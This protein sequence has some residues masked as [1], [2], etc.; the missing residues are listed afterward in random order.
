MKLLS[1]FLFLYGIQYVGGQSP[2]QFC[3][4]YF[5]P[6]CMGVDDCPKGKYQNQ[7]DQSSCKNCNYGD[8]SDQTK[9]VGC[10]ECPAGQYTGSTTFSNWHT[11]CND[12]DVGY[13]SD[14]NGKNW[15]TL[16]NKCSSGKYY[17]Q[18]TPR[19]S[20]GTCK[21]CAAGKW[22]K[23]MG[24]FW[25]STIVIQH[26]H[27]SCD[28]QGSC[29][30]GKGNANYNNPSED[31]HCEN[32]VGAQYSDVNDNTACKTG[33]CGVNQHVV[34]CN[35]GCTSAPGCTG[36]PSGK[37]IPFGSGRTTCVD[38]CGTGKYWYG[39]TSLACTTC[40][41]GTYQDETDH[42]ELSCK[43][44]G[45]NKQPQNNNVVG[46][47]YVNDGAT[48]CVTCGAGYDNPN[49]GGACNE[50][51]TGKY[52]TS[53][54][55]C[56]T[57]SGNKQTQTTSTVGGTYI[58]S[59]AT[60]CVNCPTGYEN[61][62]S[63]ACEACPEGKYGGGGYTCQNCGVNKQTQTTSTAG[64]TYVSS[65]ATKCVVCPA[66]YF[67]HG[68]M[69]TV[70]ESLSDNF[71]E[72]NY[73]LVYSGSPSADQLLTSSECTDYATS[74]NNGRGVR[75]TFS[76]DSNAYKGCNLATSAHAYFTTDTV[77]WNPGL[78]PTYLGAST[79]K[80]DAPCV[81]WKQSVL[82]AYSM[83]CQPCSKGSDY[84]DV[85]EDCKTYA[86]KY[87]T[88]G[89]PTS[90]AVKS[91]AQNNHWS[92]LSSTRKK[93]QG[94][95]AMMKWI[96]S[97]FTSRKAKMRKEDLILSSTFKNRLG[98]RAD[99]EVFHPK[100]DENECDV[101]VNE[102]PDSFDITLTEVNEIGVVCKG[103]IKISKLKLT[104]INDDSNTYTYY[105]HDGSGW[106][107]GV[108]ISSGGDY[109]CDGRKFHVN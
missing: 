70:K 68:S 105:C 76:T 14:E 39:G 37:H 30:T 79:C 84:N 81:L 25:G 57:C 92:G 100:N 64:G 71:N 5:G 1:I 42:L 80:S 98:T 82:D 58:S 44:C 99:V 85:Y 26:H 60:H 18:S 83:G 27:T 104:A 41:A 24:Q 62:N 16:D 93:R 34:A 97:Q 28:D 4:S 36:C 2:G 48:K 90:S 89:K 108:S 43:S 33:N 74:S 17:E 3:N 67:S 15:C 101:N 21:T 46:G 22:K 20:G 19:T 72:D 31:K 78:A 12:C 56:Q 94:F 10:K 53:G 50:C 65:A 11:A 49:G 35:S 52:A 66:G 96:R 69:S 40:G 87:L 51:G 73:E 77:I 13:Y 6:F 55:E 88:G 75:G 63:G 8:Y 91:R 109:S 95:R 47:A 32:C 61:T 107:T 23:V 106:G 38:K 29:G 86:Q 45:S 103:T 7:R 102:Q 54:N 59:G 9:Q